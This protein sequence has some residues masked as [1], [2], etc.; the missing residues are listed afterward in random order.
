MQETPFNEQLPENNKP[1]RSRA[2]LTFTIILWLVI[3][4]LLVVIVSPIRDV[5]INRLLTTAPTPTPTIVSGGGSFYIEADPRGT[6]TIDERGVTKLPGV[7][8]GENPI[9]LSRGQHKIVWQAPPFLPLS[10]IV[11][12]PPTCQ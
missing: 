10:C 9:I 3:L 5:V 1:P 4:I 6:I 2:K 8:T 11:Y 7:Y 12:V